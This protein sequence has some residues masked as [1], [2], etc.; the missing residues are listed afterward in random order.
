MI[1]VAMA[2]T[3]LTKTMSQELL[4][5]PHV[6]AGDQECGPYSVAFPEHKLD[7]KWSNWS[8]NPCLNRMQVLQA[9]V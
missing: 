4:T 7:W 5:G 6:V 9:E 1:P 8:M 3:E 2:G